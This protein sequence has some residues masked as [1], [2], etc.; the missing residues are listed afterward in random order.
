MEN[1]QALSVATGKK[2]TPVF[3]LIGNAFKTYFKG[4]NLLYIIKITLVQILIGIAVAL[5]MF[6]L[7]MFMGGASYFGD[8]IDPNTARQAITL[9]A[10]LMILI[11]DL[12]YF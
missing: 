3:S 5:P 8:N 1:T 4:P 2:L 7:F 11:V 6:V 9:V 10:P 12:F